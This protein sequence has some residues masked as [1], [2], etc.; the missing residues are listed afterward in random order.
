VGGGGGV[1][2]LE[3][4]T[5]LKRPSSLSCKARGGKTGSSHGKIIKK[6]GNLSHSG[7]G[8]KRK[9]F[10]SSL[11]T[12]HKT[13]P[14]QKKKKKKKEKPK[15]PGG[16]SEPFKGVDQLGD[17]ILLSKPISCF[18]VSRGINLL[19][20]LSGGEGNRKTTQEKRR[21]EKKNSCLSWGEREEISRGNI[22]IPVKICDY[23]F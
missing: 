22:S 17:L 20:R 19:L 3:G 23:H 8:K 13:K 21:A 10:Y 18:Y 16:E 2:E 9:D 4:C 15:T 5:A 6:V 11:Q 14:P 12:H 1:K 7:K